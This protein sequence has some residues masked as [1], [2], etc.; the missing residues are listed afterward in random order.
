MCWQEEQ[1]S[2]THQCAQ[3]AFKMLK[4]ACFEGPVLAFADFD[5]PF[6]LK[7]DTGKSGLGALLLQ[8]QTVGWYLSVAY[9]SQILTIHE[10]NYHS[11]KQEFLALRWVIAEHF[12]QYLCWK[13]FVVKTD[14]NPLTT[15]WLLPI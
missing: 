14:N 8:K 6:L 7:T 10:Y 5:K 11:T 3:A 13:Q 4:K 1:V 9:M 15:F 12:Q 2:N